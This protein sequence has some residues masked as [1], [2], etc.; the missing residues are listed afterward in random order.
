MFGHAD[1]DGPLDVGLSA[2]LAGPEQ[3]KTAASFV[4]AQLG[5][6]AL[7]AQAQGL[8]RAVQRASV[9]AEGDTLTLRLYLTEAEV[10]EVVGTTIDTRDEPPQ[11]AA[12]STAEGANPAPTAAQ[13]G[14]DGDG[15]GDPGP[16]DEAPV[17]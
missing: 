17:R 3:A 12:L 11:N 1:L 2:V 6:L 13:Q 5:T 16:G 10:R 15:Q 9:V 7:V 14:V 8:G 4:Q